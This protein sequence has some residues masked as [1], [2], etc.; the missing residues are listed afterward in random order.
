MS[1]VRAEAFDTTTQVIVT[2]SSYGQYSF[3]AC[4]CSFVY[5]IKLNEANLS[6]FKK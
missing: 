1:L 3:L 6:V 5:C 2:I 4:V